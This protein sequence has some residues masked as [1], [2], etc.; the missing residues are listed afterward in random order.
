MVRTTVL[1]R[2][3][4]SADGGLR[5]AVPDAVAPFAIWHAALF[6]LAAFASA[7]LAPIA[8]GVAGRSEPIW[9]HFDA[10]YYLGIADHGYSAGP[11]DE[12]AFYPLYPA[13]VRLLGYVGGGGHTA[14]VVAGL[15][16]ANAAGLVASVLVHLVVRRDFGL[17]VAR[18]A[19]IYFAV[20]P[21]GFYLSA[22]YAE[23]LF[24]LLAVA[25]LLLTR[26]HR[27][28][29][30][31]AVAA[32][33]SATRPPGVML[34]LV[35]AAEV[36]VVVVVA[37]RAGA[38]VPLLRPLVGVAIAPTGLI[39]FLAY[40]WIRTGDRL[41]TFH[42]NAHRWHR[43]LDWPW[44]AVGHAVRDTTWGDPGNYLFGPL[45]LTVLAVCVVALGLMVRRFPPTYTVFTA[46]M[47]ALPVCSGQLQAVGRAALPIVT[48][49]IVLAE[50]TR[51]RTSIAHQM[52]VA[53]SAGLCAVF[54]VMYV[55]L[56][57]AI[58]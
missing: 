25:T 35:I 52:V 33:A 45:N 9:S 12:W 32:L 27:W 44:V 26:Q 8:T 2:L 56:V 48:V 30:A 10:D 22:V 18:R 47:I 38:R 36:I 50:L 21:L 54:L 23:S 42:V 57:P 41:V 43:E 40:G 49:L 37:R 3:R 13:L 51:S 15:V 6:G 58:A 28:I 17:G 14:H 55:L 39:A 53:V 20:T 31:G 16:V 24:V 7:Y 4:P 29:A 46:A 1:D 11:G 19:C 34:T 5:Q